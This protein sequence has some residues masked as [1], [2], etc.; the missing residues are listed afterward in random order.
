[1]I[2]VEVRGVGGG[3]ATSKAAGPAGVPGAGAAQSGASQ[4]RA[5]AAGRQI[6][7]SEAR[8]V[9]AGQKGFFYRRQKAQNYAHF[10]IRLEELSKISSSQFTLYDLVSDAFAFSPSKKESAERILESIMEAGPLSFS[11]LHCK[12]GLPKSTLY[13]ICLSLQRSGF[14][15][16]ESPRKPFSISTKF[17]QA[18]R[19]YAG[20]WEKWAGSSGTGGQ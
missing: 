13:L 14:L 15:Q 3:A 6:R 20:W 16:R 5:K 2:I 4:K 8:K 18:L 11:Q 17:S 7:A 1:M 9:R 19:Q 10:R 12:L